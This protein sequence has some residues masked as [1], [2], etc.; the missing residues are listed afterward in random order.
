MFR[1]DADTDYVGHEFS[2]HSKAGESEWIQSFGHLL[3]LLLLCESGLLGESLERLRDRS[4]KP[5]PGLHSG[6]S[7]VADR[8]AVVLI[9]T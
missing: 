3:L 2:H 8:R 7:A 5:S 9:T 4:G 6:E 1:P